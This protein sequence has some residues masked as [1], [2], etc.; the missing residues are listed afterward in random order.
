MLG[1]PNSFI[2]QAK[3]VFFVYVASRHFTQK[4]PLRPADDLGR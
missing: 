4:I 2:G 1:V 3:A